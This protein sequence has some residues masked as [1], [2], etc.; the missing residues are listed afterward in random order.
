MKNLSLLVLNAHQIFTKIHLHFGINMSYE[1]L[2]LVLHSPAPNGHNRTQF[3]RFKYMYCPLW[4]E[5]QLCAS[6]FSIQLAHCLP[7]SWYRV[8]KRMINLSVIFVRD[9]GTHFFIQPFSFLHST[10]SRLNWKCRPN[11]DFLFDQARFRKP[12]LQR[13]KGVKTLLPRRTSSFVPF[14]QQRVSTHM[15]RMSF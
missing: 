10:D 6:L 14:R 9:P 12:I 13:F 2:I 7:F 11:A 8:F 1:L 4:K 5:S 15:T 3:D